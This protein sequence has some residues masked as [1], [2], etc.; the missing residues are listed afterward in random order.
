M[1]V[2]FTRVELEINFEGEKKVEN[3][4]KDLGNYARNRSVDIGFEDFCRE[5]YHSTGEIEVPSEY[6]KILISLIESSPYFLYIRRAL[7]QLLTE[8][9]EQQ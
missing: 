9:I 8:K 6:A 5:I 1:K 7:I 2:D 3:M 4:A